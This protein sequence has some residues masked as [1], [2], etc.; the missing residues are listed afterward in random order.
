MRGGILSLVR[1]VAGFGRTKYLAL[2]LGPAGVGVLAQ[3]NQ[4]QLLTVTLGSLSM[5]VG[6]IS[7]LSVANH[8]GDH[9][10]ARRVVGTAFTVQLILSITIM[11]LGLAFAKPLSRL[12]YG[13]DQALWSVAVIVALPLAVGASG[14]LEGVLFGSNR[15]DLYVR[16]SIAA[17]IITVC[18]QLA[19]IHW[20]GLTGAFLGYPLGSIIIFIAFVIVTP[21]AR[22][23]RETFVFAWDAQ[24][25]VLLLKLS[26]TILLNSAM[27]Y[28]TA[29][30]VRRA[31]ILRLGT[32]GN[33]ILQ[34]PLAL[35]AYYTPFVTNGLWARLHPIVS[36][37]PTSP[38]ARRE[39][40][41][42]LQIAAALTVLY[43]VGVNVTR[44]MLV[45]VAYSAAFNDCL[46]LIPLQAAGDY[47]YFIAFT[48]G[49][50]L[51]AVGRLGSY[52]LGWSLYY[53]IF[54]VGAV[55]MLS[56]FE[57]R[58]PPLAHVVAAVG[59][60]TL[61][62]VTSA[63]GLLTA[64]SIGVVVVGGVLAA[65][66]CWAALARSAVGQLAVAACSAALATL[67]WRAERGKRQ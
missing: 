28:V 62:L 54:G 19:M 51:L 10:R 56:K 16:G 26:G 53:M 3:A 64:R 58:A 59:V 6:I 22:A 23:L 1:L 20:W 36:A 34:V 66:E 30:F 65:G 35:S 47:A 60:A 31:V 25:L 46:P 21:R 18:T 5:A 42:S 48:L 49:V 4:F 45:K 39:L 8:D 67:W 13:S 11:A 52:L 12:I 57:L 27:G 40:N 43:V 55:A 38:E 50:Y 32:D 2:I 41:H 33:G 29:L 17:T 15:Y 44:P 9:S 37:R 63:R 7:G 14:F 61:G 24:E